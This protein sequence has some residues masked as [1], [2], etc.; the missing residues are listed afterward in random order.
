MRAERA[1]AI[2]IALLILAAGVI[3]LIGNA[4]DLDLRLADLYFDRARMQFPW[5][6]AWLTEQFNHVWVKRVMVVLGTFF[7]LLTVADLV[8]PLKRIAPWRPQLRVIA[9]VAIAVPLS[10]SLLKDVAAS[11]CPWD[12]AR[13][14]GNHPY[15]TLLGSVPA[16]TMP[17]K[18]MPAGH[19]SGSLWMVALAVLWLPR[20]PRAAALAF[21]VLLGAGFIVGWLQQMRGAHFLTHTLWSMWIAAALTFVAIR[22]ADRRRIH[23]LLGQASAREPVPQLVPAVHAAEGSAEATAMVNSMVKPGEAAA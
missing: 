19:A 13:Y 10:V 23:G 1:E 5:R 18:C 4:S 7:L 3:L 9:M 16:G 12:L 14:G 17:G 15:V 6:H 20:R 22:L 8:R 11:H 2:I 21:T